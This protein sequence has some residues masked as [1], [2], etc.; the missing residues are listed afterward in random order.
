[1]AEQRLDVDALVAALNAQRKALGLSWRKVAQQT[2]VSPST[3][4]RM[5]QGKSPDINT[6]AA[7][8]TWLKIPAEQFTLK[9]A[10]SRPEPHPLAVLSTMLTDASAS[11]LLR[12]KKKFNAKAI[13]ALQE[14]VQA[15]VKL[16]KE[17]K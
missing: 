14:L 16:S 8:T 11:G 9:G 15:A 3:L 2:R 7:L 1:M 6:F 13:E 12:G 5:Q 10:H 17:L 4:T